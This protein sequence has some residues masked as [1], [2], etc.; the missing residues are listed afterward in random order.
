VNLKL[1]AYLLV[2]PKKVDAGKPPCSGGW[3]IAGAYT[4]LPSGVTPFTK[5]VR[6]YIEIPDSELDI[7]EIKLKWPTGEV[8]PEV[9]AELKEWTV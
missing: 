2:A 4:T 8:D 6:L 3:E 1:T 9:V 7:T 5:I